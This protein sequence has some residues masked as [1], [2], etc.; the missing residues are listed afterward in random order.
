MGNY[1]SRVNHLDSILT[2]L[3]DPTRRRVVELL[4]KRPRRAGELAEAFH[5]SA[6]AMSKHLRVLRTR[7]LVEEERIEGD[8]RVR[9]FRLRR[10]PFTTLQTWL[11]QVESYWTDQLDAFKTHAESR[12]RRK[13]R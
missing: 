7:G 3:A 2:A 5:M 13:R 8:A 12:G 4:R 11:G 9:V 6:P 10:K 1:H